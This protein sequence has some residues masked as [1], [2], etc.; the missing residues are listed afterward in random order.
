MKIFEL[1]L[2]LVE[3]TMPLVRRLE[4]VDRDLAR[5]LRRSVMSVPQRMAE[6]MHSRG[7]NQPAH[8]QGA[9][10]S[11]KET[12]ASLRIAVAAGYLDA[13]DIAAQRDRCDH[14]S[15]VMHKLVRRPRR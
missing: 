12:E 4:R 6:G 11:A 10:A 5:Q 9:A 13:G 14:V 2:Q 8:F 7:G 1:S 3:D 15:A